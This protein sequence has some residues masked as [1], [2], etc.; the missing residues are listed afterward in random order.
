MTEKFKIGIVGHGFVG[1]AVDYG[2]THP[3]V[4]KFY[5]DPLYD[6]SIDD[7]VAWQPNTTFICAPTPMGED[8]IIS[9]TIVEDAV[10]KLLHHTKCGIAIKSTV[11][12]DIMQRLA[13]TADQLGGKDRFVYNPEFLTEANAKYE[14]VNPEFHIM[15][16]TLGAVQGLIWVYHTFS[17]C[18]MDTIKQ[19]GPVE[20][21]FVKYAANTFLAMKVTFFNQ[22]YDAV[23]SMGASYN[24]IIDALETDTRIGK[25]HMK[26][27]GFDGKR[28]FGGACFPKDT[29]A[30]N[31]TFKEF[32]LLEECIKINNTY[33]SKYELDERE[34]AQHVNYGQT[35]KELQDQIDGYP[36]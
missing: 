28:G 27:P 16:G 33:R 17:M 31:K 21:A 1:K 19:M 18:N 25:T 2:F 23:N 24:H 29:A 3:N 8:G 7:L 34:K 22:L 35:K 32:T 20:A 13:F 12:P 9:A 15:G 10:L 30:F 5:V 14:F 4:E 6:T 36:V 26:V 11:T